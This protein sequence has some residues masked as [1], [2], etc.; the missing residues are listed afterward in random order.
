MM[1]CDIHMFYGH[2]WRGLVF[3]GFHSPA[4]FVGHGGVMVCQEWFSLRGYYAND[5]KYEMLASDR[6]RVTNMTG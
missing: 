5:S 4:T 3:Q 2:A 6:G 1:I